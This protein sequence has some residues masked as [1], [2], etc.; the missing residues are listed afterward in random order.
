MS[1]AGKG[2]LTHL[3]LAFPPGGL[4]GTS[5]LPHLRF[6]SFLLSQKRQL[7]VSSC[8]CENLGSTLTRK[9]TQP[10]GALTG[11]TF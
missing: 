6:L 9:H 7:C 11:F 8:S 1:G 10:S 4:V 5:S 2:S 3:P